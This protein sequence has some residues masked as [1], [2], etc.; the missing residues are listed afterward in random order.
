VDQPNV[1]YTG[2]CVRSVNGGSAV[3]QDVDVVDQSKRNRVEVD[4]ITGKANWGQ[5]TSILQNQSFLGEDTAQINFHATITV[6]NDV[7]I[8]CGSSSDWQLLNKISGAT[9]TESSDILFTIGIDRI[10][11][12]FF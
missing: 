8:D 10:W 11:T 9:D 7:F 1:E 4:R 12:D 5:T 3:L 6:V 2:D